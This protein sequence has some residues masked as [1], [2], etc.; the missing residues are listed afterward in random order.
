MNTARDTSPEEI[1][2]GAARFRD[3]M[4]RVAG[5]VHVV[6]ALRDAGRAGFT[7]TA[8]TAVSDRPPT[9]LVCANAGSASARALIE[10]GAFC[11]N[12]LAW[13]DS[14]IANAFSGEA[15][16]R[17]EERFSLGRWASLTTGA[18]VLETALVSFDC[19]MID[20]TLVGTHHIIVGEVVDT[21]VGLHRRALV[22]RE[23]AYHGV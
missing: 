18:P 1:R 2:V 22:Y 13:E 10:A 8:V 12:T 6:T 11:V 19:R 20:A 21:R 14:A 4:S 9:L 3:A 7:A 23:R 17:G 15:G 5:A 16:L